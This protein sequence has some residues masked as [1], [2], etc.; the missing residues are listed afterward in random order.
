MTIRKANFTWSHNSSCW[1]NTG[2]HDNSQVSLK[3]LKSDT[4]VPDLIRFSEWG[5]E[6]SLDDRE[7][8]QSVWTVSDTSVVPEVAVRSGESSS[9]TCIRDRRPAPQWPT[10]WLMWPWKHN[11]I[12]IKQRFCHGDQSGSNLDLPT[13]P[14]LCHPCVITVSSPCRLRVRLVLALCCPRSQVICPTVTLMKLS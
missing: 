1:L 14:A 4:K 5:H 10:M 11:V 9:S 8:L 7:T 2:Y 12:K 3:Y 6:S 13:V